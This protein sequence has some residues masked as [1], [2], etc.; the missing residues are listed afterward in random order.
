MAKPQIF[1]LIKRIEEL[2]SEI[3]KLKLRT[4]TQIVETAD[5]N[6]DDY[7]EDGEYYFSTSYTPIG[8]PVR[9]QWLVKSNEK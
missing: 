9:Y 4:A 6:L 7:V 1:D 5:T 3:E 8:I 2:E